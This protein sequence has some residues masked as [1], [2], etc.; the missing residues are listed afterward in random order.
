MSLRVFMLLPAVFKGELFVSWMKK[1]VDMKRETNYYM[2]YSEMLM[3][4]QSGQKEHFLILINDL[5]IL[6]NDLLI[7]INDLLILINIY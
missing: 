3:E 7:L 2:P 6:I 4:G 5:L 1:R